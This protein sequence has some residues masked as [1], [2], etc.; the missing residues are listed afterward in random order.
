MGLGDVFGLAIAMIGLIAILAIF[1]ETYKRRL[2]FKERVLE[3][4][5]AQREATPGTDRVEARLR[6]LER[7]A[8]DN[9]ARLAS[10]IEQL[11]EPDRV[12]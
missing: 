10:A 7:I 11:R 4:K 6:V 3:L 2:A 1:T 9:P 8:T 12:A 5:A